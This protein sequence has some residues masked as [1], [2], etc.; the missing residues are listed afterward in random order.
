MTKFGLI[1]AAL[2]SLVMATPA[3]AM[4]RHY[5]HYDYLHSLKYHFGPTYGAYNYYRG[6]GFDRRNTFD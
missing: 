6:Y 3:T 1:G 4:H 2:L 5:H